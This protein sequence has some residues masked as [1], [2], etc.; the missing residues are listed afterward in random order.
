MLNMMSFFFFLFLML[1]VQAQHQQQQQQCQNWACV[2]QQFGN[3]AGPAPDLFFGKLR[4]LLHETLGQQ[5]GEKLD[6]LT[7]FLGIER[8]SNIDLL[9]AVV[10]YKFV[11]VDLDVDL[12]VNMFEYMFEYV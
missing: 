2:Q 8:G 11:Y 5:A 3:H 1:V 9:K 7:E 6:R 12:D 10:R 4:N